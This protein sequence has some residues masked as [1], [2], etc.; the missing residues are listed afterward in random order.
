MKI[1]ILIIL[2]SMSSFS[3]ASD[4][5]AGERHFLLDGK[6]FQILAGEM[7]YPR[8]PRAYW[9][10]RMQMAKAMGLNTINTYVFW[11]IHEPSPGEFDFKDNNDIEA[12]LR[13]AQEEGLHV[14]LRPGPY[15]C[16][17]WDLGGLPSWLLKEE[18]IS[19]RSLDPRYMKHVSEWFKVLGRK[20]ESYQ[21]QNGGPIIA[22]QVENEYGSFGSDTNYL[23]A[24]KNIVLESGFNKSLLFTADPGADLKNGTIPGVLAAINFGPGEAKKN[25]GFLQDHRASGPR[26]AGEFWAGWF[27]AWGEN[28]AR[29]NLDH[30][31][32]DLR[33]MLSQ[34]H[35]LSI[36]MFHGGSSFGW[37]NGANSNGVNY[38]PFV[39][40]YDYDAA[41]DE[42][43]RPTLKY[44][45]MRDILEQ[46]LGR[47]LPSLPKLDHPMTVPDFYPTKS[48]SLWDSLPEPVYSEKTLSMEELDQDYG[49][50]LYRVMVKGSSKSKLTIKGLHDFAKIYVNKIEVGSLDRRL[51]QNTLSLELNSE[52]SILDLLVENTG[53]VNYGTGIS[54][55]RKGIIDSVILD[56][57]TLENWEIFSLPMKNL[58]K[59][60]FK[61][62]LCTGPCFYT[63]EFTATSTSDTFIDTTMLS[64]GYIWVN[65]HAIGRFW[66]I[67][68]QHSNYIPGPW[69]K[70][71]LNRFYLFDLSGKSQMI[72]SGKDHPILGN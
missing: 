59:L 19:L 65:D 24:M 56:D 26:F 10:N 29:T 9:R 20:L 61:P 18:K 15:V 13:L 23:E 60:N 71:G 51:S 63:G 45:A 8:I 67:G 39:S 12:F 11:N 31:L 5:V 21:I 44:F 32:N 22:V 43:G 25:F 4:F 49:Y 3:I 35:S 33:W 40:S 36:Y 52:I 47:V 69:L 54:N 58:D 57:I 48:I 37:M 27:D 50:I 14:I 42:S 34:G 1:L 2:L 66:E 41:L 64:K 7:H 72:L 46:H 70:K 30:Q 6:P 68:P 53:R 38:R 16:A 28:H 62:G 17:E 55:E